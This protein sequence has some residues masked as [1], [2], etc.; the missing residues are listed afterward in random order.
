MKHRFL[1]FGYYGQKNTNVP[2]ELRGSTKFVKPE[3]KTVLL[4]ALRSQA[5]ILGGGTHIHDYQGNIRYLKNLTRMFIFFLGCRFLRKKI[6]L[7]GAG[8]GPLST[9]WGRFLAKLICQLADYI[10][11]REQES[12]EKFL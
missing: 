5:I 12:K 11:V 6:Y 8:I 7:L 1:V 10:S 3:A 2:S 9:I 4:E